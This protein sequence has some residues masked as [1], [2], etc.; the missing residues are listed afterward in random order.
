MPSNEGIGVSKVREREEAR[1]VGAATK[2][3]E[4]LV[5]RSAWACDEIA[6]ERT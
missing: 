2:E 4:A 6:R 5:V 3:D 1:E